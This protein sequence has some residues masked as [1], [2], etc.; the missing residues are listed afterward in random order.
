LA[1]FGFR[2][3]RFTGADTFFRMNLTGEGL[4]AGYG[5][6]WRFLVVILIISV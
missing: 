4:I 3:Q 2:Q 6:L 1:S 5:R